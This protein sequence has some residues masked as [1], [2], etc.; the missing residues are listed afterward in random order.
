MCLP[1][2]SMP[3]ARK[4]PLTWQ[5]VEWL[6]GL[7]LVN[8][9][10]GYTIN[11]SA[12]NMSLWMSNIIRLQKSAWDQRH[13]H[14]YYLLMAKTSSHFHKPVESQKG[15]CNAENRECKSQDLQ[16]P[17]LVIWNDL[18][19]LTLILVVCSRV[20]HELE[21]RFHLPEPISWK[22]CHDPLKV[23]GSYEH[24]SLYGEW[25]WCVIVLRPKWN[26]ARLF[27]F[28]KIELT[29]TQQ[30]PDDGFSRNRCNYEANIVLKREILSL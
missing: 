3:I 30:T 9:T 11:H 14:Q 24:Y 2:A 17:R 26:I 19:M 23:H 16:Y 22:R 4:K 7:P 5:K 8:V 15:R 1:E 12:L 13:N 29:I 27:T 6:D 21:N 25:C 28:A 20:K 10:I 18:V